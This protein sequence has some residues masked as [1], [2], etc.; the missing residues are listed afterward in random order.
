MARTSD[1]FVQQFRAARRVSTPILN[2]RTPDPASSL[3]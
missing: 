3:A 1:P 2:V